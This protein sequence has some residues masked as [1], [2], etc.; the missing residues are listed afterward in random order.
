M[1]TRLSGATICD[2]SFGKATAVGDLYLQ[3]GTIVATPARG[4]RIDH[5][6][7]LDGRV[8]MA[9]G[10]DLHTHIG[11]GK[12]NLARLLLPERDR[13]ESIDE[14]WRR[15]TDGTVFYLV[16]WAEYPRSAATWAFKAAVRPTNVL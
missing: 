11:G 3:D 16:K 7:K 6:Y 13:V 12:V 2:P 4:T 15:P 8:L 14:Q 9:G 1:L 5:E 10:I